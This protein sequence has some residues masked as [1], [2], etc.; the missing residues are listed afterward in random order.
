MCTAANRQA[1]QSRSLLP[2][3]YLFKFFLV[4]KKLRRNLARIP[5]PDMCFAYEGGTEGSGGS[6]FGPESH[7]VLAG[8]TVDLDPWVH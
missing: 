4:V 2:H 5:R 1:E 8:R 3:A 6:I 7:C